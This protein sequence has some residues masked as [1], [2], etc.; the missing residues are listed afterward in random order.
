MGTL[1]LFR[2]FLGHGFFPQKLGLDKF[3]IRIDLTP[4][5]GNNATPEGKR[6]KER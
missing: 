3:R 2:I 6:W 4:G 5:L 1:S